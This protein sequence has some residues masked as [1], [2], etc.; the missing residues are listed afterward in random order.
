MC[1]CYFVCKT[2]C[3]LKENKIQACVLVWLQNCL[4][5]ISHSNNEAC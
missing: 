1:L 4:D 3:N 5:I 2:T